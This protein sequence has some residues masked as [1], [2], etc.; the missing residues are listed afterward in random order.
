MS[1]VALPQST[2]STR[3][4]A[5]HTFRAMLVRDLRVLRGQ[6]GSLLTR[7]VMQPLAFTFVFTYVMPKIGM[8]GTPGVD[9]RGF[10]TILVP[11]LVAITIAIQGIMAVTMPLLL[12]F[13]Y[14]R[15]IEDR[16]MAPVPI[17]LIGVAKITSG[18]LQA[19]AAGALVFPIVLLVHAEDQAPYVHVYSWPLFIAVALLSALLGSASGLLLGTVIDI[20]RAQ[21]FFAVVVT[22]MTMLGCVYYSWSTLGPLPWLQYAVLLN[23]VVYMSEGLRASLTPQLAHMP[24]IAFMSALA[25]GTVIVGWAAVTR[26]VARVVD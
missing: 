4:I 1:V 21:Q 25:G 20:K 17:W 3:R 16:A 23:P 15:E 26:F 19:L 12:E 22:P 8:A 2:I 18:A 9:G 10:A 14:N 6:L 24:A 7:S 5:W 13:S 11:G